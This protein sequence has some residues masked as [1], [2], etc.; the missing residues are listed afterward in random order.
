[1]LGDE[2]SA[3][4]IA[5]SAII[6]ILKSIE[7]RDLPTC[8]L[9]EMLKAAGL[10]SHDDFIKY[11]HH[12]A[13][14]AKVAALAPVVSENARNGDPLALDILH[15]GAQELT[16]LVKSVIEQSVHIQNRELV[17]AGGV[18]EHNEIITAKLKE[19]LAKEFPDLMVFY[20][21]KTALEGACKLA[22]DLNG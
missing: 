8:M 14:K 22:I 4:W 17:L 9:D 7:K 2:G 21:K 19:N 10:K 11:I 20:P 6:R 3:S 5:K 12:D 18:L 16:L 1:M 13:D 15:T